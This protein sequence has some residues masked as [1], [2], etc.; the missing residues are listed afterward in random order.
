MTLDDLKTLV[1]HQAEDDP[2]RGANKDHLM[3]RIVARKLLDQ[4]VVDRNADHAHQ[5]EE[6]ARD[7][8]VLSR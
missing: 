3:K 1:E 6:D 7:R 2:Y 8:F 5:D 4:H